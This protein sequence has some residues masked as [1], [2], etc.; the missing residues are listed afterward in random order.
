MSPATNRSSVY[1]A[2]I[3]NAMFT[4]FYPRLTAAAEDPQQFSALVN[5]QIEVGALLALPG[6]LATIT[7]RCDQL[8]LSHTGDLLTDPLTPQEREALRWYL[9]EYWQWPFE[10]FAERGKQIES[11][12]PEVGKRL[13]RAV[14]GSFQAISLLQAWR[15]QPGRERQISI[16]SDMPKALSLPWELLHDGDGFLAVRAPVAL[17]RRLH[18]HEHAL[19]SRI[20]V[21]PLRILFIAARPRGASSGS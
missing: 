1:V 17:V 13:Y 11:L 7:L 19:E 3:L 4:D 14:F 12:L 6:I 20:F 10:G 9:E 2:V 8:G 15:L 21:P 5:H 18:L 16:L